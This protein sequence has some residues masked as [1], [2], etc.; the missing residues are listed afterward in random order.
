MV[1]VSVLMPMRNTERYTREAITSILDQRG[2]DLEIVVVDDASTD[3]SRSV[4]EGLRDPRVKLLTG[5]G[6]G[7]SAAWNT[8]FAHARGDI[9]LQCDSD[10][11][12][13]PGRVTQQV[14]F[15]SRHSEY[16]A[17]CGATSS[18]D[19]SGRR[20]ALLLDDDT[21]AEEITQELLSG[22]TRSHFCTFAVRREYLEAV[23]AKREYFESAED[24]DLQLRLA[25]VCRVWFER[26][27]RYCYRLHDASI[28]HSQ[29]S[30]RRI[31][32][33][34]YAR[35][36]RAQRAGGNIDDVARGEP[37]IP[38]PANSAP[39]RAGIQIQRFLFHSAW[40]EHARGAKLRAIR[41]GFR[42]CVHAPT[43][44][45]AW[46]NWAALICKP[47]PH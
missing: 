5:E 41:T 32:F 44:A 23:G 36:L 10:D 6:R 25:E 19:A 28:T 43:N 8:A 7:V 27:E 1:S 22:V 46:R 12:Y 3:R 29:A 17:V 11:V 47:V 40:K 2:C 38:P 42:A 26:C 24:I 33:E 45:Q 15:L 16:G 9:I 20:V 4:V 31:F 14:D 13:P 35:E 37:C 39:D 18:M 34:Q 30:A 21:Q